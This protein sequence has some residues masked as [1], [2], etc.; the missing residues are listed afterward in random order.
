MKP[1]L[2]EM[3]NDGPQVTA[4]YPSRDR[5]CIKE[6]KVHHF[7]DKGDAIL[8]ETAVVDGRVFITDVKWRKAYP[9]REEAL[10]SL[11]LSIEKDITSTI[12]RMQRLNKL[13]NNLYNL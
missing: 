1:T 6:V 3:L 12:K 9:T 13:K 11:R 2:K 7:D 10:A 8:Y 4:F 5:T